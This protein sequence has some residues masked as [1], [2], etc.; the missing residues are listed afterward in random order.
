MRCAGRTPANKKDQNP[1]LRP[2]ICICNDLYASCLTF[3]R[4]DQAGTATHPFYEL[5]GRWPASFA[6]RHQRPMP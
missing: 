5:C 3:A 1:L 2:I 4:A 6:S